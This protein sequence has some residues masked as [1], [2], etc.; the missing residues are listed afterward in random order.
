M[1][2]DTVRPATVA[3]QSASVRRGRY[4]T[5]K[6]RVN[7]ARPGSP[8]A[9]VTIKIKTLSGKTVKQVTLKNRQLNTDLGYR[10]RCTLAKRV[11]R[12]YV[13]ATDTAG[14]T[15]SSIGKNRLTVR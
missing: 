5:L 7:D 9:T 12:F 14:N 1:R 13:L 15:Q 8:T 2:I 4:V 11:Y 6:Y 10:F 3:P